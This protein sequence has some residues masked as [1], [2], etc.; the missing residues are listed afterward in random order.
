MERIPDPIVARR[1]S[2]ADIMCQITYLFHGS[3]IFSFEETEQLCMV[4]LIL[5][6][7]RRIIDSR[8]VNNSRGT[9]VNTFHGSG[10]LTPEYLFWR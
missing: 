6:V 5:T 2:I 7:F 10:Q 8:M 1:A 4:A 3:N 9:T